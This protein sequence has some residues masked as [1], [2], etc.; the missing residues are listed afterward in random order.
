MKTG[1]PVKR[2]IAGALL[3]LV[4]IAL[5]QLTKVWAVSALSAGPKVLIPGVFSLYY[6]QNTGAAFG[7]GQG[8]TWLFTL[9]TILIL[10][11]AAVWYILLLKK[12][13]PLFIRVPVLLVIAGGIGNLIDR[14]SLH[15]VRDFLYFSLIDFPV[16]NVADIYV[17][18][19]AVGIVLLLIFTKD[20]EAEKKDG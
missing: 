9:F 11:G 14:V 16:F 7:I 15:Y 19:A 8:Q 18:C 2:L 10:A 13:R 20:E 1:F 3:V 17:T 6:L 12:R 4:L 5:D